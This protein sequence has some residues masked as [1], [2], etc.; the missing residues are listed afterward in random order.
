M[1]GTAEPAPIN[2]TDAPARIRPSHYPEPF[3]A[4]MTGRTKRP[5]GDLFNIK[6]FGVNLIHLPPG[7]V[8]ALHHAHSRQDEFIYVVEGHPT[9]FRGNDIFELA[10]GMVVGFPSAGLAHHLENRSG[11]DC[12]IL[13]VG[14]RSD[15]DNVTYPSDDLQAVAGPD[16][17]WQFQHKDGKP[18]E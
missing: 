5:L 12:V 13:E 3:A 7:S 11:V 15:G 18:Y 6:N 2:A 10:P 4:L 9:L 8:S 16:G 17:N 1:N 14:D